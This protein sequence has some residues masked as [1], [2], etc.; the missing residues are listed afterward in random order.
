MI[1]KIIKFLSVKILKSN[2]LALVRSK[3]LEWFKVFLLV[4]FV[5]NLVLHCYSL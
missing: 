4:V 1:L 3:G 2:V 5:V